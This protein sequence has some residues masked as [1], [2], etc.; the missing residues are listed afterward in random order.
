MASRSIRILGWW[1]V[2]RHRREVLPFF[3]AAT[4]TT[5]AIRW[6]LHGNEDLGTDSNFADG[7]GDDTLARCRRPRKGRATP[8]VR[9]PPRA[10]T[11]PTPSRRPRFRV[12][13]R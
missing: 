4:D 6:S 1:L 5:P 13:F 7:H 2:R 9:L 11:R 3:V 10:G 8:V 12:D